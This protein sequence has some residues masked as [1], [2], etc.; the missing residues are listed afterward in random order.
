MKPIK[1]VLNG[2]AEENP[3]AKEI[4]FRFPHRQYLVS[5]PTASKV[6]KDLKLRHGDT[7]RVTIENISMKGV[8]RA[9]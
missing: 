3:L 1:L 2:E 4:D 9:K 5:F 7:I 6:V 8:K